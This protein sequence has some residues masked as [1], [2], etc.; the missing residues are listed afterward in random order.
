LDKQLNSASDASLFLEQLRISGK[1]SFEK[2]PEKKFFSTLGPKNLFFFNI[3][4]NIHHFEMKAC[5]L[6]LKTVSNL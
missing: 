2:K 5:H 1:K 3:V 4:L 6:C